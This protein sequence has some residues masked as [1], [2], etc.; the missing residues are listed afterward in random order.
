M[1]NSADR[2]LHEEV[3]ATFFFFFFFLFLFYLS[4]NNI[5]LNRDDSD[6][7]VAKNGNTLRKTTWLTHKQTHIKSYMISQALFG[8]RCYRF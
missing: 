1:C 8:F 2:I 6:H 3:P 7:Q 4:F 5:S